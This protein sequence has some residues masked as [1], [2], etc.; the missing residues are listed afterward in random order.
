M[1]KKR[2]QLDRQP[3]HAGRHGPHAHIVSQPKCHL[4]VLQQARAYIRR[5]Q[6]QSMSAYVL[7]TSHLPLPVIS[8]VLGPLAL[9]SRP[10]GKH[11]FEHNQPTAPLVSGRCADRICSE[12]GHVPPARGVL[13]LRPVVGRPHGLTHKQAHGLGRGGHTCC[14]QRG[15]R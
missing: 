7:L 5:Y 14:D 9:T 12:G 2:L 15:T 13:V 8:H 3:A 1:V 10:P 11:W 6:G 4:Q